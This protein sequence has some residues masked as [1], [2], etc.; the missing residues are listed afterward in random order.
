M[1]DPN[2][3][4]LITAPGVDISAGTTRTAHLSSQAHL[5]LERAFRPSHPHSLLMAVD[6]KAQ[7]VEGRCPRPYS[8]WPP[9]GEPCA[10]QA[11]SG[12]GR[13]RSLG[14]AAERE[15]WRSQGLTLLRTFWRQV[16][17]QRILFFP[18]PAA[19]SC[20][21]LCRLLAAFIGTGWGL[22]LPGELVREEVGWCWSWQE[23]RGRRDGSVRPST[24]QWEQGL[25]W[26]GSR[27]QLLPLFV[28]PSLGIATRVLG[29]GCSHP[30]LL[31]PDC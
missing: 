19:G 29:G 17:V 2:T 5:K 11:N 3:P 16:S 23:A 7:R 25:P 1:R 6:T 15:G 4:L 14:R 21:H 22:S 8:L 13:V 28:M 20:A 27:S 9:G 10:G 31:G 30:C 18:H 12:Q 24:D 26:P